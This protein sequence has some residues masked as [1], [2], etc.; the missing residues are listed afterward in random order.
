MH[1]AAQAIIEALSFGFPVVVHFIGSESKVAENCVQSKSEN[2]IK[3]SKNFK[4]KLGSDSLS[5]FGALIH[6]ISSDFFKN[7]FVYGKP[8]I[9]EKA[10][11]HKPSSQ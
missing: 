8:K 10:V 3:R 6:C 7:F 9:K 4:N 1:D 11:P 5:I 2:L